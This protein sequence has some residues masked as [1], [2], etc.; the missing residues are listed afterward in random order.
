MFVMP[1]CTNL[2]Q[3]HLTKQQGS[4]TLRRVQERRQ[5]HTRDLQTSASLLHCLQEPGAPTG[6]CCIQYM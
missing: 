3:Q 2:E 6:T 5:K 1:G 4:N